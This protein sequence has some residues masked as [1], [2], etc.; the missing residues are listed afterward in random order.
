[1]LRAYALLFAILVMMGSNYLPALTDAAVDIHVALQFCLTLS[2]SVPCSDV[3]A[4]LRELGTPLDA[5]LHLSVD[6]DSRYED[7]VAAI[8]SIRDAGFNFKVG[9]VNTSPQ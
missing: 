9:Y 6:K 5:H 4:K 7:V 8:T 3:G 1:M 2:V